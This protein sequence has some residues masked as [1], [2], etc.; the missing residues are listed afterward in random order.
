MKTIIFSALIAVALLPLLPLPAQAQDVYVSGPP[1][2]VTYYAVT[3]QVPVTFQAPAFYAPP[4]V[5]QVSTP[6]VVQVPC[7][8]P[9]PIFQ[10]SS[11]NVIYFGG[12]YTQ[13]RPY[14]SCAGYAYPGST[15]IY[16]GRGQACQQGY[17]F[18]LRR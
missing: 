1:G 14:S 8:V 2:S 13:C 9:A 12:T 6:C 11:P 5:C 17:L 3:P 10:P 7:G 4:P 15:V 16:F 18:G